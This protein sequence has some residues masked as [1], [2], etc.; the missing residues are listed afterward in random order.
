MRWNFNFLGRNRKNE[1]P[2]ISK[3]AIVLQTPQPVLAALADPSAS[4]SDI[5]NAAMN[6]SLQS[7]PVVTVAPAV[8]TPPV[9]PN[10]GVATMCSGEASWAHSR[11]SV[12]L[13]PHLPPPPPQFPPVM[14]EY[15]TWQ[16][17]RPTQLRQ[18]T[19]ELGLGP[20]N[21]TRAMEIQQLEWQPWQRRQFPGATARLRPPAPAFPEW[22][23]PF[24]RQ[25]REAE[26]E[27]RQRMFRAPDSQWAIRPLEE[28]PTRN[29]ARQEPQLPTSIH[30]PP[31]EI[32]TLPEMQQWYWST[33]SDRI[34]DNY[35]RALEYFNE[36]YWITPYWHEVNTGIRVIEQFI[37]AGILER[38]SDQYKMIMTNIFMNSF[39]DYRINQIDFLTRSA[40]LGMAV[41]AMGVAGIGAA[42]QKPQGLAAS[43]P[44]GGAGAMS[45][46]RVNADGLP[47]NN[48]I[49]GWTT[50]GRD[51]ALGRDGGV[52]VSNNAM[53]DAV[54]NPVKVINQS[55]GRT[56]FEGNNAVVVLNQRG[57]VV[58]VW[59]RGRAGIQG[60]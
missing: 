58:T 20:I 40:N 27:A 49:T 34:D 18:P 35:N 1:K 14:S 55:G 15:L 11:P 51:Q 46:N 39:P 45:G 5:T 59:P 57:E 4:I 2:G 24:A 26:A 33:R 17:S 42:T 30:T 36:R 28:Y 23:T 10:L 47:V 29:V 60:R 31:S 3:P 41:S 12:S 25:Q 6:H 7:N 50:H 43:A 53:V 21:P 32:N 37:E 8:T 48:K 9:S 44:P 56:R 22:Y 16:N 13:P 52:R 38:G 19:I 54:N